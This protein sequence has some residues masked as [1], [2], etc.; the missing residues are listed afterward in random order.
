MTKVNIYVA[1]RM[2]RGSIRVSGWYQNA[3]IAKSAQRLVLSRFGHRYHVVNATGQE[4]P[5]QTVK[6]LISAYHEMCMGVWD[7][8]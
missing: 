3:F 5:L 8:G 6:R 4:M 1:I 7:N 2:D